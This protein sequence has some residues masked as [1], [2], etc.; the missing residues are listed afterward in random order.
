M[1]PSTAWEIAM[2]DWH[3][4]VVRKIEAQRGRAEG[5]RRLARELFRYLDNGKSRRSGERVEW[6]GDQIIASYKNRLV[7]DIHVEGGRIVVL[8]EGCEVETFADIDTALDHMA[9]AMA[10]AI[11]SAGEIRKD[12][13]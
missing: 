2:T 12:A 3:E 4:R 13:A 6:Q 10:R 1:F 5:D 7:F 9:E 8:H 11:S